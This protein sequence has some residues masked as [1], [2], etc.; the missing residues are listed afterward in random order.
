MRLWLLAAGCVALGGCRTE[1]G[2]ED[3]S[4]WFNFGSRRGG[5]PGDDARAQSCFHDAIALPD[6]PPL[7]WRGLGLMAMQNGDTRAAREAFTQY[8]ATAPDADDKA[9]IEHYLAQL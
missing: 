7:A 1:T 4:S 6:A 9:M 2:E 8:R 3:S 5:G